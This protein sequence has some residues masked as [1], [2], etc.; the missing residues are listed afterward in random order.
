[1]ATMFL[2]AGFY[3][4]KIKHNKEAHKKSMITAFLCST[5]FLVGYL[6]YHLNFDAKK[7]P[8]IG[9]IKKLYLT[10]LASHVI[11][12]VVMLPLIIATFVLAFKAKWKTHKKLGR[13]TFPIWL[14]VSFTG[15]LIYILLY[16]VFAT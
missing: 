11:L 16:H 14:Y 1:M 12:A 6:Y 15:V 3:F 9:L 13:I 7:F 5:C 2:L 4:I 10:M 8:D